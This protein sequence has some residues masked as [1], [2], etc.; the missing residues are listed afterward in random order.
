MGDSNNRLMIL[1]TKVSGL[2]ATIKELV[3]Q[4]RL[5]NLAQASTSVKRRGRS[6]KT[7]VMEVDED[8]V[9]EEIDS[10]FSDAKSG[11]ERSVMG[12]SN[13]PIRNLRFNFNACKEHVST[14]NFVTATQVKRLV[15]ASSEFVLLVRPIQ[16]VIEALY[17]SQKLDSSVLL[18]TYI[19]FLLR[20]VDNVS[21][22]GEARKV[23]H[24]SGPY[25]QL[26]KNT[27]RKNVL[28]LNPKGRFYNLKTLTIS[29]SGEMEYVVN[30]EEHV[31]E[32]MFPNLEE[33]ELW[34]CTLKAILN[35]PLLERSF[36]KLKVLF[37][38]SCGN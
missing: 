13:N 14:E 30:V 29:N 25:L 38:S 34:N 19:C 11:E 17:F 26:S 10:G 20:I 3:E 27:I 32:T 12:T 16:E 2:T 35:G 37:I 33:L 8:N 5:T 31:P 23:P 6:M 21:S 4:L 36:E 22:L 18:L 1:E 24:K 15:N 9:I 7:G 28:K